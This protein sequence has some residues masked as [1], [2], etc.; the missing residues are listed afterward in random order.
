MNEE[1]TEIW[2]KLHLF[3]RRHL[4][5]S[6]ITIGL[7][8]AAAT[9]FGVCVGAAGINAW[10][11]VLLFCVIL[12]VLTDTWLNR[13]SNTKGKTFVQG[14]LIG[15]AL[16]GFC[17]LLFG[18]LYLHSYFFAGYYDLGAK[19]AFQFSLSFLGTA[20]ALSLTIDRERIPMK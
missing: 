5:T 20:L 19:W 16:L 7:L 9:I 3:L 10:M 18:A 14:Y 17:D 6:C 8:S 15:V 13:N 4:A 1:L 2:M 12:I 11:P